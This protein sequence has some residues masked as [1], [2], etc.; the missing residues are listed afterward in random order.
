[1]TI[2]AVT[3]LSGDYA[4]SQR[5]L[6]EA[7][8]LARE[9]GDLELENSARGNLGVIHHLI[10]DAT[11]SIDAY[12]RRRGVLSRGT[13]DQPPTRDP[14]S[15]WSCVTPTWLSSTCGSTARWRSDP[16]STSRLRDALELGL[17]SDL[18]IC[19]VI[20]AERRL[21]AGDVDEALMLIG[22]L[23]VDPRASEN[24]VQEIE[25]FLATSGS[26]GR[27]RPSRDAA[28]TRTGLRRVVP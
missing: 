27:R 28:R 13:R 18:G 4:E 2:A 10:G 17:I 20:E 21:R 22:A 1:M 16:I 14:T 12:L 25:R 11:G 6:L 3:R 23:H 5:C 7:I 26:G 8:A 9:I 15:N 19:L 24:D